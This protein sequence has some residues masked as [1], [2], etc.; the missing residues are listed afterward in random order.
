[1]QTEL[2]LVVLPGRG[3][4]DRTFGDN[5]PFFRFK[6]QDIVKAPDTYLMEPR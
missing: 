1:M 4:F 2:K 6:F 3:E 5:V